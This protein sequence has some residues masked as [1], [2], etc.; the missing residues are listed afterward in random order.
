V[1]IAPFM[2]D[3]WESYDHVL[4]SSATFFDPATLVRSLGLS[5]SWAVVSV[6]DTFP[7]E[8]APVHLVGS[9]HLN[10]DRMDAE[11]P[12]VLEELVRIAALH[13][14]ERGVIHCNSYHV[15]NYIGEHLKD[16]SPGFQH[17]VTFHGRGKDRNDGLNRWLHDGRSDSIFVAV[18]MS[19]GLDLVGDRA[20][21]QVIIKA[22][23]PN[24][25][26]PWVLR[27]KARGDNWYQQQAITDI[28]QACGR[29]MRSKDDQGATYILDRSAT[30][31]L[32]WNWK[33]LPAWFRS[34]A[35]RPPPSNNA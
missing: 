17:R 18:S 28:L 15:M 32:S 7:S 34:R 25:G 24:L 33:D 14:D 2:E 5:A 22:P 31:L 13:P 19:E 8:L 23:Y 12:K 4:L 10:R 27:R 26:D 21:W 30:A 11:L 1:D 29:V 3:I 20:R 35:S 9:V 16:L 6:P